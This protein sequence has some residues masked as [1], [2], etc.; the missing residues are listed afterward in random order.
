[1]SVRNKNSAA[2]T[3]SDIEKYRK[4]E[5]SAREMHDLEQTAL[6]DPFLA[7]ALEGL[8]AHPPAPE[9]LTELHERL[10]ARVEKANRKPVLL[11]W[12]RLSI[13]AAVIL[14]LGLG[15][16]F[17][18]RPANKPGE[19]KA[20]ADQAPAEAKAPAPAASIPQSTDSTVLA[21]AIAQAK[22]ITKAKTTTPGK[23][24]RKTIARTTRDTIVISSD[25][26]VHATKSPKD[27]SLTLG[28][29]TS[30]AATLKSAYLN[31]TY[32]NNAIPSGPLAFNGKVLDLNNHPIA[33]ATLALNGN[34]SLVVTDKQG[35]FSLPLH[36]KDSVQQIT[37]SMV[38]YDRT[39]F[40]LNNLSSDDER[41][42]IIRLKPNTSSL[43]E[44]VVIG[45]GNHRS[46][47]KA[48]APTE[49]SEKLDTA[50]TTAAPIIGRQAYLQYLN[51]ASRRLGLDS[52]I[53]GTET[54]SFV[55]AR[56]GSL[57][58]FKIEKSLSPA[59]DGAIIR[60]ITEGPSWRLLRGRKTRASVTIN[61]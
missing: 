24:T 49:S 34:H 61:F 13:A 20:I 39:S 25:M 18:V 7:D 60:L 56:N 26:Y 4:G 38:G 42:N 46:E 19:Y 52:T 29:A 3:T 23:T 55:V 43:D 51:T 5:L 59:H 36:P 12:R 48:L 9:D 47:A 28:A 11:I 17:F 32:L 35:Q 16:T 54:I 41:N 58:D 1:M 31:N 50:W 57:S 37:V 33:G 21:P 22:P 45:Y 15:Y 6:D 2:Y 27:D 8:I 44:V 10:T 40:A 53:T 14:L 30:N